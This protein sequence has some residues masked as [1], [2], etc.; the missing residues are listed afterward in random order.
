MK[1]NQFYCV[2][3]KEKVLADH[4]SIK[5]KKSNKTHRNMLVSSCSVCGTKLNKFVNQET[6]NEFVEKKSVKK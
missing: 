5:A 6:L 1:L 3:C 2:K 4:D